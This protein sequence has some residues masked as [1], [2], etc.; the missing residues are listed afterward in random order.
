MD[1][2]FH[3]KCFR[4]IRVEPLGVLLHGAAG[5]LAPLLL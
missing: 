5:V 3:D 2:R 1:A 4:R